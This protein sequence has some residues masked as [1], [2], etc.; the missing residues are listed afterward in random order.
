[1]IGIMGAISEE[2]SAIV[3]EIRGDLVVTV[4]GMR[5]YHVGILWGVPVVAVY[6][7]IG[8]VAAASTAT[9]LISDFHVDR[10]IFTGVAGGIDPSLNVGDIVI[11]GDLY[12]H[13]MDARPLF[14]RHEIPLL[15]KS[16]FS[17][18]ASLRSRCLEAA[19]KF[20]DEDL[21]SAI[22]AEILASFGIMHP[23]ALEAGIAS[24]DKFF[25]DRAESAELAVRLPVACVEMEGAAVAQVCHEY[26]VEYAVI[27]TIS[28]SANASAH[29]DF[30][31]F[32]NEVASL[33]SHGVLKRLFAADLQPPINIDQ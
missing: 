3:A 29:I 12:Q 5:S 7:R 24:G 25:A 20:I 14:G 19:Q 11:A 21:K 31:A 18:S 32:I 33:Y 6:S 23:R 13:D 28:D 10:I 30:A 9:H 27:R 8:K 16:G 15:G 1:M 22:P 4:S 2:I 26:G 17:T